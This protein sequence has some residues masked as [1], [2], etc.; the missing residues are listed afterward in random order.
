[1]IALLAEEHAALLPSIRLISEIGGDAVLAEAHAVASPLRR[2]LELAGVVGKLLEAQPDLA[3]SVAVFD[4]AESLRALL[5]EMQGE[6]ISPDALQSLDVSD[7]SGHWMRSLT[8]LGIVQTYM[9]SEAGNA[10][11]SEARQ[12]LAVGRMIED[13]K[14]CPPENPIIVAGSTGSRGTTA[15]LMEAVARLRNGTLLL[16]GFDF[17]MP[18]S[19]W[20]SMSCR[21]DAEDHPQFRFAKLLTALELAPADV[22]HWPGSKAP[23]PARNRLFSLALRPAPVTDQWM[24]DGPAL[25][26]M[27][28]A[29]ARITLIEAPSRRAE[30][31]SIAL[32]LRNAAATGRKAALV[33]PDRMLTRRVTA[34]LNGWGIL[35]DDSGGIPLG[36]S[37]PG[38]FLRQITSLISGQTTAVMLLALLKHPLTHTGSARGPHL[39]HTR[40]FELW[41]RRN[42]IAFVDATVIRRWEQSRETRESERWS[43][44]L[45]DC[46]AL[47]PGPRIR[48][49]TENVD[50]LLDL[51]TA[52]SAG[53][54][55]D[56]F[57]DLWAGSAGEA[58]KAALDHLERESVH[59]D[60][61]SPF[62]FETLLG[63]FLAQEEVRDA[64]SPHPNVM[65]WGT[66]EARVQGADLV[67]LG[68]LN[69]GSWPEAPTPDPWLNR[70]LRRQAGL[71]L[72]DR[73]IGLSAHDFQQASAAPEVVLARSIRDEEAEPVPSRWLN[74][75]TNLLGGLTTNNGPEALDQ[76]RA[77]GAGWTRLAHDLE[78]PQEM[79]DPSPRPSPIPPVALRPR[80]LPVT[81]IQK[82]IRDPYEIYARYILRLKLLDPLIPDPGAALRGQIL[83]R[84]L[85]RFLVGHPEEDEKARLLKIADEVLGAEVPWP[86]IRR[87]WYGRLERVADWFV[88]DE[89]AR[90][91]RSA[92]LASER[93]GSIILPEI[94]FELT[95][96]AD[97]ID[98][99]AN[100][101]L[102]IIDY[103]TG[104][105]PTPAEMQRFDKQLLLEA[106]IAEA[107]GFEGIDISSVDHVAHIG[108]GSDP[109]YRAHKLVDS[110]KY[111]FATETVRIGLVRLL[112]AMLHEDHG[113]TAR[114]A[115]RETRFEGDF[116]HLSRFGEWDMNEKPVGLPVG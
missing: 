3:P 43:L 107:G 92:F 35:P 2:Q 15:M 96:I 44:W 36:L 30:A 77:R 72:P 62:E 100:G 80:K 86:L 102:V 76:M 28:E 8:F 1:M 31:T 48:S 45:S 10:F 26:S 4:L 81:A 9:S 114:R 13:W 90:K 67:V 65:I 113:F 66:L 79:L 71:L 46:L 29:T 112:T 34:V 88:A 64:I 51:A 7:Q 63:G 87:S 18:D 22:R 32:V 68:G 41:V 42:G 20:A 99:L 83:H 84:I 33:S 25:G 39:L 69:E 16:P 93:R 56:G 52:F 50:I 110:E 27:P 106:L 47:V 111:R 6:G 85:E 14:A 17:D 94:G 54:D 12:R 97:R 105:T 73:K 40:E 91:E 82:L 59:G 38:R 24:K 75:L 103:K 57:G 104:S 101:D 5:D 55:C 21:F 115:A 23:D 61:V 74:R 98:R 109:E 108:L 37:A 19:V 58:A 53:P 95:A 49:L 116:D 89:A 11:G 60:R 70:Q 78:R